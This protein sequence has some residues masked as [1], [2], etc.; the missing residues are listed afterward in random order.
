MH[1]SLNPTFQYCMLGACACIALLILF[2]LVKVCHSLFGVELP[3]TSPCSNGDSLGTTCT[4]VGE[5]HLG[6]MSFGLLP[7]LPRNPAQELHQE[8]SLDAEVSH[9]WQIYGVTSK[10]CS[11]LYIPQKWYTDKSQYIGRYTGQ[12]M[13]PK[14]QLVQ[15]WPTNQNFGT[16]MEVGSWWS[17]CCI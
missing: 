17:E 10:V 3:H 8:I 4:L 16:S 2:L 1:G 6:Q 15:Y 13:H 14:C 7:S 5:L 12:P 11:T 9:A